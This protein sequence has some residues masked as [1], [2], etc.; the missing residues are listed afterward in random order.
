[1]T[2]LGIIPARSGSKGV[3]DKNIR[4]VG[5]KPLIAHT[6]EDAL[7]S[8]LLDDFLVSTDSERYAEIARDAGAPVPSLRPDDLATDDAPTIGAVRHAVGEYEKEHEVTIQAT[9]LLQPTAPL[10]KPEDIDDAISLFLDSDADSLI[11]CFETVDEHPNYMYKEAGPNCVVSLRDQTE[12]PDRRQEFEPVYLRNGAIYIST[13][14]LVFNH[15]RVYG[16]KPAAY[17]MPQER[18]VN[19]D[20]EFD[21]KLA[22]LLIEEND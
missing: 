10:R 18:S 12:V 17:T 22:Q 14:D 19:V 11:T 9:V 16:E 3:P 4:E 6:I 5:G 15:H 1:M 7:G 8:E 21:L 2:F 20:E 13:R